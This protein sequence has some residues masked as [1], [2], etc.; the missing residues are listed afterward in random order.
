[1]TG[2]FPLRDP[3]ALTEESEKGEIS[4]VD[5]QNSLSQLYL[6][7][8]AQQEAAKKLKMETARVR[9]VEFFVPDPGNLEV[10]AIRYK[11]RSVFLKHFLIVG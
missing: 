1:M 2:I 5:V 6:T 10:A 8:E 11:V 3:K 4:R 7:D 9:E